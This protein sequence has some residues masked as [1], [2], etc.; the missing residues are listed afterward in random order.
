MNASRSFALTRVCN[1]LSH[2]L[3]FGGWSSCHL[4]EVTRLLIGRHILA[5]F[6]MPGNFV[7]APLIGSSC[8]RD[9]CRSRSSRTWRCRV[10]SCPWRMPSAWSR[11][12]AERSKE[13]GSVSKL[14]PRVTSLP[15]GFGL[16]V[17]PWREILDSNIRR[18][19]DPLP[20]RF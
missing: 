5:P 7:T 6:I 8:S 3:G 17:T 12:P 9:R 1:L 2:W 10:T 14:P 16:K 4:G 18:T 11:P 20:S 19:N 13:S 15:F